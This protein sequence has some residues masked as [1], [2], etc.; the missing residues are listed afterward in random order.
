MGILNRIRGNRSL[1]LEPENPVLWMPLLSEPSLGDPDALEQQFRERVHPG[2]SCEESPEGP[3]SVRLPGG[4][5][6]IIALM[7]ARIPDPDLTSA[8]ECT[9]P[10][11]P[12]AT[13]IA[14]RH[15]AH[16]II[17]GL[18][19][20]GDP[21]AFRRTVGLVTAAFCRVAP[22][23]GV[24][25]GSAG[26]IVPAMRWRQAMRE[27]PASFPPLTALVR[28]FRVDSR[29]GKPVV[30][31][32]GLRPI[33]MLDVEYHR[34]ESSSEA[35]D[36]VLAFAHYVLSSGADVRAGQTFGFSATQRMSIELARSRVF[37]E[38]QVVRLNAK[39][40]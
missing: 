32:Q 40:T 18:L 15:R 5:S 24:Y 11:W 30:V 27:A 39:G 36:T 7:P 31:T 3:L 26:L 37:P 12:A 29:D 20:S 19:T 1:L 8:V 13:E 4:D 2:A 28:L 17:A 35:I 6:V 22:V 34:P 21:L 9:R 10:Y 33:G 16:V 25:V 38:E 14:H 23:L